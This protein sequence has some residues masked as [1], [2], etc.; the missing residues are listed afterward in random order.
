MEIYLEGAI[1]DDSVSATEKAPDS[2]TENL[3]IWWK[4]AHLAGRGGNIEIWLLVK[5]HVDFFEWIWEQML[6][7]LKRCFRI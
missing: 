2:L 5:N 7:L 6:L 3:Q 1:C 4:K